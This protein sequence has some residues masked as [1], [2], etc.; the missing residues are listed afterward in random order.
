MTFEFGEGSPDNDDEDSPSNHQKK[1][2]V[3]VGGVS[4]TG[5]WVGCS[6]C[7]DACTADIPSLDQFDKS[8]MEFEVKGDANKLGEGKFSL[9]LTSGSGWDLGGEDG[10]KSR[11]KDHIHDVL[12]QGLEFNAEN[13]NEIVVVAKGENDFGSFVSA[14]FIA[15][16]NH[17]QGGDDKKKRSVQATIGRRYLD[18]K[19]A[20][21]KWT[22]EVLYDVV[23]QENSSTTKKP[24]G[25]QTINPIAWQCRCLHAAL[26]KKGKRKR[27]K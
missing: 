5:T 21:A 25:S 2:T 18:D 16:K 12:L 10:E 6:D 22:L 20:R 9:S 3:S 4:W 17:Q 11:H 23:L 7:P 8:D 19:D 14:G 26:Q 13:K 1:D 15:M 24:D 27:G